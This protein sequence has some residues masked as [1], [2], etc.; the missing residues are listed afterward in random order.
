[1]SGRNTSGKLFL[2]TILLP[3]MVSPVGHA[4][5]LKQFTDKPKL[6][7]G[8][9]ARDLE[10]SINTKWLAAAGEKPQRRL[11]EFAMGKGI[12][13][14][15]AGGVVK[16][17]DC[18]TGQ[19]LIHFA[20]QNY[21]ATSV[22]FAPK[23]DFMAA[24]FI[25]KRGPF[26]VRVGE[27]PTPIPLI[28]WNLAKREQC[29]R[30]QQEADSCCARFVPNSEALAASDGPSVAFC[31]VPGGRLLKTTR[32]LEK[33][34][35]IDSLDFSND[36]QWMAI[37]ALTFPVHGGEERIVQLCDLISLRR[38]TLYR[39]YSK[40]ST[41]ARIIMFGRT[42]KNLVYSGFKR[43]YVCGLKQN[44]VLCTVPDEDVMRLQLSHDDH[45]LFTDGYQ[46][47]RRVLWTYE[48]PS[49][50]LLRHQAYLL[51]DP[52]A[53]CWRFSP[54]GHYLATGGRDGVV[55]LW[56]VPAAFGQSGRGDRRDKKN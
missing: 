8:V 39:Q 5:E 14:D 43:L 50:H 44:K 48:L 35:I 3:L 26:H 1:M 12:F 23:C 10:F 19:E 25:H 24:G 51:P 53:V 55:R 40:V 15:S 13:P 9:Y 42:G 56:P 6:F 20:S 27:K 30:F 16:V 46:G 2:W 33:G 49:G 36:G 52:K 31:S 54:N 38:R 29:R 22:S 7:A 4:Q 34:F 11:A 18:R 17:W 47:T 37:H 45:A 32:I 28:V 41:G 21:D